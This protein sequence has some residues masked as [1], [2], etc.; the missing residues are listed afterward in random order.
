MLKIILSTVLSIFFVSSTL[1]IYYWRDAKFEPT[2]QDLL[3]YF[4]LM[5]FLISLVVL[6]PYLIWKLY[7]FIQNK[8]R[9]AQLIE[10]H[11]S[12]DSVNT[13][14]QLSP[15]YLRLNVY[16]ASLQSALGQN[17]EIF[18]KMAEM[19]APTLDS[20]L[21][22]QMGNPIL[23]YRMPDPVD[24]TLDHEVDRPDIS[25]IQQ[26]IQALIQAEL[27]E[28]CASLL[29]IVEHLKNSAMF[30]DQQLAYEYRMHPAWVRSDYQED[31]EEQTVVM[32]V[33]RL[34]MLNIHVVLSDYLLHVWNEQS[35]DVLVEE[36]LQSLG[37]LVQQINVHYHYWGTE[38]AY[39]EW[40]E[41]LKAIQHQKDEVSYITVVDSAI[42]QDIIDEHLW[43]MD[44]YIPAEFIGSCCI[45]AES[46]RVEGLS[47]V[48][49]IE[50]VENET[51]VMNFIRKLGIENLEQYENETPF[52]VVPDNI[53][54]IK[55]AQQIATRIGAS[56]I[57]SYHCL[58]SHYSLGHTQSLAKIF[59]FLLGLQAP[60]S[61]HSFM[62]S[63]DAPHTHVIFQS[64][65]LLSELNT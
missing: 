61:M 65:E 55:V 36:Y 62:F 30:Y 8:Q 28:N 23:S 31:E 22:N 42:D 48:K 25:E 7:Q 60:E 1:I 5:P 39:V 2:A 26:R 29:T 37:L 34:N 59:G 45:S 15:E 3:L 46:V 9:D 44:Q 64:E 11:S 27:N 16:A 52:F 57:Q 20:K 35:S 47:R 32:D 18:A 51:N 19:P 38:T 24:E 43:A 53:A 21:V 41:L 58:Y 6:S 33:P 63:L 13:Q 56:N 4:V 17:Q 49:V 12:S 10:T 54:Q 14:N 50:L 40:I